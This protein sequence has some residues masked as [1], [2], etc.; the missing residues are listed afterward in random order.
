[1]SASMGD[2][3][4]SFATGYIPPDMDTENVKKMV[5]STLATE[6]KQDNDARSL[7]D[8]LKD[9]RN[10]SFVANTK[11]KPLPKR[12]VAKVSKTAA[13]EGKKTLPPEEINKKAK[14]FDKS[15]P[16][17][18]GDSLKGLLK[19]IENDEDLTAE[20]LL[21]KVLDLDKFPKK[22]QA[23]DA[24]KFLFE[25]TNPPL[26]DQIGLVKTKFDGDNQ[27]EIEAGRATTGIA[28][29][30]AKE[31]EGSAKHIDNVLTNMIAEEPDAPT[32]YEKIAREYPTEQAFNKFTE[33]ILKHVN[34][35]LNKV[36]DL[37]PSLLATCSLVQTVQSLRGV[38]KEF[39]K[40]M[41]VMKLTCEKAGFK[42]PSTL[43]EFIMGTEFMKVANM[44]N[45][46]PLQITKIASD[47]VPPSSMK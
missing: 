39:G 37:G 45:Y 14:E 22:S 18:G 30:I 44:R 42:L 20:S 6:A 11:P 32:L 12:P 46:S 17:L 5:T 24:L 10:A 29:N 25:T 1:M 40:G 34:S 3:L 23:S 21:A 8:Q 16:E 41:S 28:R 26:R 13:T 19:E 31:V 4:A 27:K 35:S 33:S 38:I 15:N 2:K 7:V 43:N 36:E 9:T 47:M